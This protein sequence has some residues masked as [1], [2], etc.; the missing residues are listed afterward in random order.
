MRR[1]LANE[2][3][4]FLAM[5]ENPARGSAIQ[6]PNIVPYEAFL[7]ADGH[8]ASCGQRRDLQALCDAFG[9]RSCLADP[10]SAT[11]PARVQNRQ[12]VTDTPTPV[13]QQHPTVW[14]VEK[15][16]LKI[17]CGPTTCSRR[18]SRTRMCRRAA[19]RCR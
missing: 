11:V 6:H 15:L 17:G 2:G 10:R 5:R 13:M 9:W 19:W 14:W 16:E 18:C 12:L 8:M 3:M 7:T 4:N 1:W